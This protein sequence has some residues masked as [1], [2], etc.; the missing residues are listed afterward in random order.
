MKNLT[1]FVL[2]ILCL[3]LTSLRAQQ[4]AE[5][6]LEA[7]VE[8]AL[9]TLDYSE[10]PTGILYEKIPTYLPLPLFDG[11][12]VADSIALI[13]ERYL[14][15]Y[16]M[17]DRAHTATSPMLPVDALWE[18]ADSLENSDTISLSVLYYEYDRFKPY[19][20]DNDLVA[21]QDSQFYDVPNRP[22][23]PYF[24]DT[25]F[26]ASALRNVSEG[27]DV[28]FHLPSDLLFSNMGGGIQSLEIDFDDGQ[29]WQ[30]LPTDQALYVSYP[31]TGMYRI[32]VRQVLVSGQTLQSQTML[33]VFP[34]PSSN[35]L[36]DGANR[37]GDGYSDGP[38]DQQYIGNGFT[39]PT[40]LFLY[41]FYGDCHTEIRKPLILVE[42]FDPNNS[43]SYEKLFG[44]DG[45]LIDHY[46]N[47]DGV[48]LMD[49][50]YAEGY[51]IIYLDFLSGGYDLDLRAQTVID[52]INWINAEKVGDEQNVVIGAS[53]GGIMGKW[54]LRQM[55]I[56]GVDHEA[57]WFMSFDSPLQGANVP[58]GMQA[59]IMHLGDYKMLGKPLKERNEDLGK[60]V[61]AL[62]SPAAKELLY[63]HANANPDKKCSPQSLS[64]WHDA[65]YSQFEAL[66]DLDIPHL[67][68]VNGA[69]NGTGQLFGIDEKLLDMHTL[70]NTW[71]NWG[72]DF[73]NAVWATIFNP[74]AG[75]IRQKAE[76][77]SLPD[78]S[79]ST[80]YKGSL[81]HEI[82][83]K[84][85]LSK[86]KKIIKA[87]AKPYDSAPGGM[88]DFDKK[89]NSYNE[90]FPWDY[91]SFGFIPTVS[92]LDLNVSDLYFD[93]SDVIGN[94][95]DGTTILRSYVGA[96]TVSFQYD[97]FQTNQEHVVLDSRS[98]AYLLYHLLS[99][100]YL[101][102]ENLGIVAL[103]NRTFNFGVTDAVTENDVDDLLP[104]AT[105]NIIDHYL[106]INSG[107]K[108]W[109]NR[110]GKIGYTDEDNV[111]NK[112]VSHLDVF[113]EKNE[114]KELN[115][116]VN[117]NS[118]GEL[119]IGEWPYYA[120]NP[121]NIQNTANLHVT[122]STQLRI[123]DGGILK[124]SQHS[125]LIIE[126]G[127]TVWVRSGGTL[128]TTY[129]SEIIVESGGVLHID[130]GANIDLWWSS[131]TI[132]IKDG[133]E[134]RI[135][136]DFNFSGSG[137]FQFDQGNILSFSPNADAFRLK[138]QD[139][140]TRFIKLNSG[141]VLDLGNRALDL[142]TGLVEFGN[143]SVIQTTG[144]HVRTYEVTFE[145]S[146][147]SS[148]YVTDPSWM[149][150][151]ESIF[152]NMADGIAIGGFT[153]VG[154]SNLFDAVNL[155]YCTFNECA[156]SVFATNSSRINLTHC[157][158]NGGSTQ[159]APVDR[160]GVMGQNVDLLF[161]HDCNFSDYYS[162]SE[163]MAAV[164]LDNVHILSMMGG[165]IDQAGTGILAP[166][167]GPSSPPNK[168]SVR[169]YS[170]A[171]ISNC[172]R[173]H[174]H[175]QRRYR[176]QWGRLR[177]G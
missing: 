37:T 44:T 12:T 18:I 133:G 35:N 106:D 147:N 84:N 42:G 31:D 131:S 94:T 102:I 22:E 156:N 72:N 11:S 172:D 105:N 24:T 171:I 114:C 19:A 51:D 81:N 28:V 86:S 142:E 47:P 97:E 63:Y 139:L 57:A 38:D 125:K 9:A 14:I 116:A 127:G 75:N 107:G 119:Y 143:F 76:V 99:G 144:G 148:F 52:A 73:W 78:G 53:A 96:E 92:A 4:A 101:N 162:L 83:G 80:C 177:A 71:T 85:H 153:G 89:G 45:L 138:G 7:I 21:Y 123:R 25:L 146:G 59:M 166:C 169:L 109:I 82:L 33:K 65:F 41:I 100:L 165:Q 46:G 88:R 16:G 157:T 130:P 3:H 54:A 98:A 77:W 128:Q 113:I 132:H 66:G 58:L 129:T 62:T 29:G 103:D 26:V 112:T 67:A 117:I 36:G 30:S 1:F 110:S 121:D 175:R 154:G 170:Y 32:V 60:G 137:F 91:K 118:G 135:N 90:T 140:T 70:T 174:P 104:R 48:P 93:A 50:L 161:L 43:I 74:L 159:S 49:K 145:G 164:Y 95:S 136:G 13:K 168:S 27:E 40:G 163:E 10:V 141:A 6:D 108:L 126:D 150:V 173:G 79:E 120:D 134:L 55:E 152:N 8:Q 2:A 124:M 20:L 15:A 17:L 23:S 69:Q 39:D 34:R 160:L 64:V 149:L 155:R 111:W 87:G 56:D 122:K 5:D 68:I 176:C 158:F 151:S 61:N 167:P 115:P